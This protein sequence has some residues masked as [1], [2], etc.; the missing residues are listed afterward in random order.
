M[1]RGAGEI[2]EELNSMIINQPRQRPTTR[3]TMPGMMSQSPR[4]PLNPSKNC[5]RYMGGKDY[6]HQSEQ[7]EFNS[8]SRILSLNNK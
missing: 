4:L 7:N 1:T 6:L 2:S 8:P 3:G 5:T